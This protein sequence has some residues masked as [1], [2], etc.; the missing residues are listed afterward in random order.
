[1]A[2]NNRFFNSFVCLRRVLA[3]LI[4]FFQFIPISAVENVHFRH[5]AE[6]EGLKHT[7]IL[8]ITRDSKGYMWFST[9]YGAYRYDGS[10]FEEYV[11]MG[12]DN[13]QAA[14]V[15]FVYEDS[16]GCI[17]FGTSSG[18]Y[19]H[20]P[21]T[22]QQVHY[23]TGR[24]SPSRLSS[25]YIDDML[26]DMDGN[27]W[28]S[29]NGGVDLLKKDGQVRNYALGTVRTLLMDS[30]SN[31]WAGTAG[32]RLL[33][34]NRD[35]ADFERVQIPLEGRTEIRDL[36]QDSGN[37]IWISTTGKG[38]IRYVLPQMEFITYDFDSGNLPN[39]MVR[40]VVEDGEGMIWAATE[41]G[42][43]RISPDGS[44]FITSHDDN[45]WTLNDNAIYSLY[46][47]EDDNLW[48]GTFFGGVNV[49]YRHSNMFD[50]L[51]AGSEGYSQDSKVVSSI[52]RNG[53]KLYIGTENDGVYV[54]GE[55]GGRPVTINSSNS[56]LASDN[57]HSICIDDAGNMWLGSYYGGL[58]MRRPGSGY[59]R[60]FKT[61]SIKGARLSSN[62]V[63][64]V[65]QDSRGNLMIG[66]QYGGLYRYD[67]STGQLRYFH[68][69]LPKNIFVWDIHED[70]AGDI[71]LACHGEGIWC[72]SASDDYEP[73]L[74]ETGKTKLY[75]TFC[76]LDDGRML[77]GTEKEGL[78]CI[79][80]LTKEVRN[81][82]MSDGLPDNTV[83]GILQDG[84]G[85]IWMSSNAGL[86]RTD[87]TFSSFTN[88]TIADGLPT[89]R[90]NYNAAE[91]ID[92]KLYFGSINGVVVVDPEK[93]MPVDKYRPIRFNNLYVNN[94]KQKL[95]ESEV[96]HAD[97]NSCPE[98]R[99]KHWQN[100][101]AV[102]FT[103]NVFGYSSEQSFAY[104]MTGLDDD[105]H[106]LGAQ[107]RID[108]IGLKPGKYT[109]MVAGAD[110]S[111]ILDNEV[112]LKIRIIPV[113]WQS[114]I[115]KICL[116]LLVLFVAI[117]LI[118]LFFQSSKH[119]HELELEKLARESEKEINEL[120]LRFFVNISHEFKTPLSLILGPV[121][122]FIHGRVSE[123]NTSRYFNIIKRNADKLL[124]LINEL[125]AFREIQFAT[126][127]TSKVRVYDVISKVLSRYDWLFEDKGLT[128]SVDVPED[129]SVDADPHKLEKVF[130]NLL[131]N[132]YK[133]TSKGDSVTL[134]AVRHPDYISLVVEDTGCGIPEEELPYIFE[135]FFSGRSYDMYSSGVGLSYVKSLVEQHGGTISA[136][137]EL[138]K[139]TR[140]EMHMPHTVKN[141]ET[142]EVKNEEYKK[143]YEK[144]RKLEAEAVDPDFD[145]EEY[146]KLAAET[147]VLI[148]EDDH[149]MRDLLVDHLGRRYMVMCADN[150]EVAAKIVNE[151]KV[152]IVISDVMLA[153]G[154]TGFELCHFIKNSVETSHIKVILMTV[155]SEQDYKFQGYHAGAD[156]YMLK[157]FAFSLLE[158][159]IRNLLVNAYKMRESYKIEIDMSNVE[160]K[161]SNTDEQLIRKVVDVIFD[162]LSESEFS[163]EDLCLMVGMSKAT[164]YRKL[165][166]ITGQSTNEFMQNT[167]LKYA[168]RIL[169]ETDRP[170]SD[171]AYEVGFS[172]PYYFS[173]AFKKLFG[174]SPKQWRQDSS[175]NSAC[176]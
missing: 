12:D 25:T 88:Y 39:D 74:L 42:L 105:W 36:F 44:D 151:S 2:A 103:C 152:D 171:V 115:A 160:I 26:E 5:I 81:I 90:F 75:V 21:E 77:A 100:T 131:S 4:L 28:I 130:D 173:R 128:V 11:F 10:D 109:L 33:R 23:T 27:F 46:S 166:A 147:V 71:W 163:V 91:K 32:G 148:V 127:K 169:S 119:K 139:Y 101:I 146:K 18:L 14:R 134:S 19:R 17:W 47:D 41:Q 72:M 68:E 124:A 60:N 167:R 55:G 35:E 164:L 24:Y 15:N 138:G 140:I 154:M 132:A 49:M 143:E 126:L 145:K 129:I 116:V 9:I 30:R 51:L 65:Y 114:T 159:R 58:F 149:T 78:V 117:W 53:N 66:T 141:M 57:I 40:Q 156:A 113:W 1:M 16:E 85:N 83:Y 97:L 96:L 38:L 3:L 150:G 22:G 172:D 98:I 121:E 37:D 67:Y 174:K 104:R 165:K 8:H 93:E 108:F 48:V 82:T 61:D 125:L 120:K 20:N 102:D 137:S 69:D 123:E 162:H 111:E 59:F 168:A 73:R 107:K 79:D 133:H 110:G 89:N 13:N 112:Q 136:S 34:M 142:D 29:G 157:P 70:K 155:L 122:Q 87:P 56:N 95:G 76:E 31:I 62:H 170:V 118:W 135:R 7:W 144:M 52:V 45:L 153:G 158:L 175:E 63:Y 84:Q 99:L 92:G 50:F 94:I 161:A 64:C 86:C 6:K 106:I 80:P 54:I 176:N 43:V